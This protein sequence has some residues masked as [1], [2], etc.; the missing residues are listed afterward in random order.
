MT[1]HKERVFFF[2][3]QRSTELVGDS[4]KWV[5]SKKNKYLQVKPRKRLNEY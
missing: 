4:K 3:S 1:Q 5:I 2:F